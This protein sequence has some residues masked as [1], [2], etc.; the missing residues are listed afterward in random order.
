MTTETTAITIL[1]LAT[2]W[3]AVTAEDGSINSTEFARLGLPFFSGC[4]G[5]NASMGPHNAHPSRS[6]FTRCADCLP[7]E[8]AFTSVADYEDWEPEPD[9]SAG[10]DPD[11]DFDHE[12]VRW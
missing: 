11:P 6:G 10:D 3:G 4:Q 5:C 12:Q 8:L 2:A 7:T 9:N 1:D